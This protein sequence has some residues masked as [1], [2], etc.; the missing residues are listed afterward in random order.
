VA[1]Y[2]AGSK[3]DSFVMLPAQT[4]A[5][6]VT[7]FVGQN[8]GAHK[9]KR[10]GK[11]ASCALVI[12]LLIAVSMSAVLYLNGRF[13]LRIFTPDP[14]VLETGYVFLK[15][16]LPAYPVLCFTQI[17]PGALRGAG[18]VRI[19][20]ITSIACY[21]VVRQIYLYIISGI[22]F[23]MTTVALGYPMTWALSAVIISIYYLRRNWSRFEKP[24]E[25]A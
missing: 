24:P 5:L 14:K 13:F 1:G 11:G 23:S 19:P 21:V 18:D 25:P 7:T 4:M 3:V 12:G 10:A 20:T 8:L 9:V 15:V 16:F 17:L 22:N 2:S 6:A